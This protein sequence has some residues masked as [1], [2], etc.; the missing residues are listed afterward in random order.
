MKAIKLYLIL[1]LT[2]LFLLASGLYAQSASGNKIILTHCS[3]IDCTGA[4]L[5][6]DMAI[7]IEGNKIKEI[8]SGPF[9][10]DTDGKA[11]LEINLKGAYV[12]P[13]LWNMHVHLSDL[14]PDVH[15]MLGE[16][17]ILP[18][19]VRAGRNAMDALKSGFTGLRIVGERDYID[20]AWRDAFNS[21]VFLGPRIYAA[22][23]IVTPG[24]YDSDDPGWPVEIFAN[25]PE[26]IGK[27]VEENIAKGI[28][29][30]KNFAPPLTDEEMVLIVE[31]AHKHGLHVKAHSSGE[32]AHRSVVAGVN[33]LEHGT[34]I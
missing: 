5:Q 24:F 1:N 30:V 31:I 32:S 4:P 25:G 10:Y 6:P 12:L 21:G 16:E 26:E 17:A 15:D 3:L 19:T 9:I 14:L 13:G 28:D 8:R 27:K 23:K 11:V 2:I 34:M 18:A 33:C 22:G 29:L 7:V 20:L